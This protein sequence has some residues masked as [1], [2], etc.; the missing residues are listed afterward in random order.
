MNENLKK[1]KLSIIIPA[2]NE[3]Q[4]ILELV[5]K[6]DAVK[7][8]GIDKEI[9]IVEDCSKDRTAEILRKLAAEKPYKI[10]FQPVNSGKGAALRRGFEESTGDIL[11]IQDADLE[12]DPSEYPIL[13]QPIIDGKAEVVYGTRLHAYGGNFRKDRW[14]YLLHVIGNVGLTLITNVLYFTW[15]TDMETGYKVFTRSALEKIGR[16]RARRF[17]FEPEITAKFLKKGFKIREVPIQYVSRDFAQGKKI[18]WR[19]GLKAMWYL[20]FYRFTD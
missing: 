9:V 6:V 17:D 14:H 15:L 19:D 13:L 16:L 10:L 11:L 4:T 8:P 2:Y 3:E 18:T 7:L 1:M 20:V 5:Q 12:Y